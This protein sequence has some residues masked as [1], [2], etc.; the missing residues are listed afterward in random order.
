MHT[1]VGNLANWFTQT[2][3]TVRCTLLAKLYT[4][5]MCDCWHS[6]I[7]WYIWWS[8]GETSI[9][10]TYSN[11]VIKFCQEGE[12]HFVSSNI[13]AQAYKPSIFFLSQCPPL[14]RWEWDNFCLAIIKVKVFTQFLRRSRG[15]Q[16]GMGFSEWTWCKC[17]AWIGPSLL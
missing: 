13:K 9:C 17:P 14:C 2:V 6:P 15:S 5:Y 3:K 11:T 7:F 1:P 12:Y 8:V 10:S 16:S 4:W